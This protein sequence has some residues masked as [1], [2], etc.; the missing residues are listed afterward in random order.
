[1]TVRTSAI[2]LSL[3]VL[4]VAPSMGFANDGG[5]RVQFFQSITVGPD[6]HVGDVVCLFCAIRMA[7][8]CGD[9]VAIFGNIVV[10]GAVNGDAVSVGG[11]IKLGEDAS[12]GG[13]TVAIGQGVNRHPNAVVKGQTVS[14]AGTIIFLGLIIVP[15]LPI[16]L[17]VA[18]VVWLL[19]RNRYVAPAQVAYRR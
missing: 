4:I 6:D 10:D 13:D 5:D 15:L 16:I 3:L 18:F 12:V 11:G 9:A 2:L 1:M 17:V 19:R 14:Q 8:S 7:G